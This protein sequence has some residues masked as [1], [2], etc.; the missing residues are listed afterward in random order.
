[1]RSRTA[2]KGGRA[3]HGRRTPL[4]SSVKPVRNG[5]LGR[6]CPPVTFQPHFGRLGEM[7]ADLDEAGSKGPARDVG[8]TR[9][10]T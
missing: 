10:Q 8:E 2:N 1:M 7:D 9:M 6:F 3:E 5:G 4:T